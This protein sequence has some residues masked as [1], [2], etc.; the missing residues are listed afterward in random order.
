M[1]KKKLVVISHTEHYKSV[2][3]LVIGL[4]STVSEINF[5][6][7][8]W[9]E[10]VHVACFYESFAP[11]NSLPYTK[12]NINFV[13]IPPYGGKTIKSKFLILTKIP[14]IIK[15]VHKAIQGATEV[16]LRLP[17]SMGLFLLPLFAF[18]WSRKFVFWVKYAGNWNQ[19]KGPLSYRL[20]KWF[21]VKNY[22]KCKVTINGFWP[23][24]PSHCYS[25][26]NPCLT[27]EDIE[28]SKIYT[29]NKNYNRPFVFCF[30]GRLD[31]SKGMHHIVNAL[32]QIPIHKIEKV[33]LVGDGIE[34]IKYKKELAFLKDKIFFHG[35]LSKIEVHAILQKADF[36]LLPSA[37]EG[38]PKVIAEAACYGVIPIV[39]DVG[40]ISH[41]IDETNGFLCDLN[42]ES[43]SEIIKSV[44]EISPDM[45]KE[46]AT[47]L[48][49]LAKKFT[50]T[51]YLHKLNIGIF[52]SLKK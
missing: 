27:D 3:G 5:L 23:D 15:Q 10:V 25:F 31:E 42:R 7:D 1:K 13:P 52:D 40:S 39:S 49:P 37:S 43:Y 22:T 2:E 4:G 16:Q 20:Q 18:V 32:R 30:V 19:K 24:Q 11:K 38:F 6:A 12:S 17:T 29:E 51:N 48:F 36:F 8:Y 44:L 47:R 46:K 21:L 33:H 41:Y 34:N 14:L 9:V 50:F 28:K 45:L 35:F 26:E